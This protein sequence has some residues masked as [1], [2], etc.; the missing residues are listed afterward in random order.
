MEFEWDEE[1]RRTNLEKHKFDFLMA[2]DIFDGRSVLEYSSDRFAERRFLTVANV[3]D[4]FVAIIW[5][6][7]YDKRRIIS[8]RRARHAEERA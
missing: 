8:L 7:R 2:E 4:T 6:P 3:E 1:K 5:T